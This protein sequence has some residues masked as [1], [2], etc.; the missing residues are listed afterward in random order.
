MSTKEQKKRETGKNHKLEIFAE[1][2]RH[3]PTSPFWLLRD[4]LSVGQP[5]FR[6]ANLNVIII[7]D[8]GRHFI[9]RAWLLKKADFSLNCV[10]LSGGYLKRDYGQYKEFNYK[11]PATEGKEIIFWRKEKKTI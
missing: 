10:K 8:F 11:I 3:S 1:F 4:R 5:F 6:E 7:R 2:Y 9:V